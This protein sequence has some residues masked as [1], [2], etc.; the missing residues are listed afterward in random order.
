MVVI[1]FIAQLH[2]LFTSQYS[3]KRSS[4]FEYLSLLIEKPNHLSKF[5]FI[6][7]DIT[8]YTK[9]MKNNSNQNYRVK[10]ILPLSYKPNHLFVN[11]KF[12]CRLGVGGVGQFS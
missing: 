12:K 3:V 8:L 5:I 11:T 7:S 9:M 10:E 2:I 1:L 6:T 4:M